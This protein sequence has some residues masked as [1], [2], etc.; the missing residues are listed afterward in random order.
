MVLL[1]EKGSRLKCG[2]KAI[3]KDRHL[4]GMTM[5]SLRQRTSAGLIVLT[6]MSAINSSLADRLLCPSV[7]KWE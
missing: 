2:T 1:P 7:K 5:T 4:F 3:V 6:Q